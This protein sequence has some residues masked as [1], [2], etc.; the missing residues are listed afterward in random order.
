MIFVIFISNVI[1]CIM[2]TDGTTVDT[3]IGTMEVMSVLTA[4]IDRTLDKW[5]CCSNSSI[6][7]GIT[8]GHMRIIDPGCLIVDRVGSTHITT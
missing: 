7:G 4:A 3:D 8:N 5:G 2:Y 1:V 6:C